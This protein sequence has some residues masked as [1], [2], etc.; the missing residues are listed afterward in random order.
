MQDKIFNS[1]LED[2]I[3]QNYDYEDNCEVSWFE[4]NVDDII[5]HWVFRENEPEDWEEYEDNWFPDDEDLLVFKLSLNP[6]HYV[7]KYG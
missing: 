2:Y 7:R 6:E 3:K 4:I 5:V 1:D